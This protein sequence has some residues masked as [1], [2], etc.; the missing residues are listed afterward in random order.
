MDFYYLQKNKKSNYWITDEMLPKKIVHKAGEF[1]GN[2]IVDAVAKS[3][4]VNTEKQQP[5]E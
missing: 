3:N 2:K 5:A 1:L 4:N